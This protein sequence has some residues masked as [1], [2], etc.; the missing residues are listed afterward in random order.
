MQTPTPLM[1]L[2]AQP[3][4]IRPI[5]AV[6]QNQMQ[7]VPQTQAHGVQSQIHGIQQSQLQPTPQAQIQGVQGQIYGAPQSIQTREQDTYQGQAYGVSQNQMQ[8]LEQSIRQAVQQFQANPR[9]L[10]IVPSNATSI[11]TVALPSE[12]PIG[13]LV[14]F[15]SPPKYGVVRIANVSYF[16]RLFLF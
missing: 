9:A 7:P 13:S 5:Q 4:Q 12:M 15:L 14:H 3:Q 6:P 10:P 16:S 8:A 2:A 11:D 1:P